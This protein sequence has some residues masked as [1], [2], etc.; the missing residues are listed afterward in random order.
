[1]QDVGPKRMVMALFEKDEQHFMQQVRLLRR[2]M[3]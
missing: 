1:M 3:A 2:V